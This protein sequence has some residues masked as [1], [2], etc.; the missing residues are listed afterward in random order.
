MDDGF[1]CS[2]VVFVESMCPAPQGRINSRSLR[3]KLLNY[4][5]C[6][7][8]R[9][10][11]YPMTSCPHPPSSHAPMLSD[12]ALRSLAASLQPHQTCSILGGS[13][14]DHDD[15]DDDLILTG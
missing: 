5:C 15:V 7:L 3:F 2:L 6:V 11:T 8:L 9:K 4:I 14:L 12:H 10:E 1:A 13:D